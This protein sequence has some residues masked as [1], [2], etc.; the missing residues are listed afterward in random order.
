MLGNNCSYNGFI[1]YIKLVN[2]RAVCILRGSDIYCL[3]V[4]FFNDRPVGRLA[5][6]GNVLNGFVKDFVTCDSVVA[7]YGSFAA[8]LDL[9]ISLLLS[10]TMQ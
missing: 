3:S 4:G 10:L 1:F 8:V 2:G 9:A 7:P 5:R 6:F